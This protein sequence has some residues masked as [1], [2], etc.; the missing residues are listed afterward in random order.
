MRSK[1]SACLRTTSHKTRLQLLYK[2]LAESVGKLRTCK[3]ASDSIA[4][5]RG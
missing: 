1:I 5:V 2:S 3:R 4:D